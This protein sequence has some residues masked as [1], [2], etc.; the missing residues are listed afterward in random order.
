MR[1]A[2]I[3]DTHIPTRL[4][5]L[6]A[7]V[8]AECANSNLII[9]SGDLVDPDIL[10]ELSNY[11][12]VKAVKGNMDAYGP[13]QTLPETAILNLEGFTICVTHGSGAPYKLADRVL[14]KLNRHNPDIIIF[15]HSHEFHHDTKDNVTRLNPGAVSGTRGQPTMAILTLENGKVPQVEKIVI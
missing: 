7:R 4:R 11:A 9:H 1:I 6:P 14:K 12:P 5:E 3:S 15:G 13:P 8:L 10:D 2:V